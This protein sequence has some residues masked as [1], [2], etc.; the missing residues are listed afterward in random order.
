MTAKIATLDSPWK[1]SLLTCVIV[2]WFII[3]SYRID[4]YAWKMAFLSNMHNF[5]TSECIVHIKNDQ[6]EFPHT[7]RVF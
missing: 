5:C 2:I 3:K 1:N 6:Y 7:I 4:T